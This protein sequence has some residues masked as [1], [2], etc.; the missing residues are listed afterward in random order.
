MTTAGTLVAM[1]AGASG[2][3]GSYQAT[4]LQA[5]STWSAGGNSGAFMWSYPMRVPPAPGGLAPKLSLDYSSQSVDGRHAAS[6]NQP[7]WIGEGFEMTAGGFIER[8]YKPCMKDMDGSANNDEETGDL[9]WETDNATLSLA[10]A[11]GELIYNAT[12]QRWHLRS[13]D[14]S[15][16]ERKTGASNGDNNGEYWVVT[17]T[18][19]VQYWFGANRLPGWASGD[20]VTNSTWTVPVFGNDPG[21]PCRATEF[22]DSDCVQAWRWNL[23]Y[24]VDL[25]GNSM[26][27]WYTK[28]TNR[29]GRDLDPD[30]APAYDRGGWLNRIDYGTRRDNGVDSVLDTPAPLRVDLG[31]AN[32]CLSNCATH[33]EVRWP[34][35]PWDTECAAAPCKDNFSPTFWR[36][37]RLSTVTTQFRAGGGYEDAERWTLSHTFPDPGDGTRAGLWLDRISHTGLV[38][39]STSLPDVEFTY[40]QLANRVDTIDFAAAMNWMRI[41]KIRNETGGTLNVTYSAP[42]CVAGQTP[43]A[44]TNTRR[45]YPVRWQP[46][47]H[48]DPVMD[49]F[50]KY[51]ITTLYETDHTGG[52]PPQGSPRVIHSFDYFGGAAWHYNDDDG[53]IDAEDKTWSDY[54]GYGRVG[55]TVGDPGEQ[56]YSE[57]RYF[58]GMHGDRAGPSGGT[59]TATVD[60]INDEDWYAGL[61]REKKTFNGPGGPVVSRETA[62][63]W[64]SPATATRTV[65]GDTV[66]ARFT[67]NGTVTT[68]TALDAGRGDRVTK[69]T[70]GYDSYGMPVSVDD[71]GEDGVAGDEVCTKTDYTPRNTTAWLLDRVHRVQK[72]AVKCAD[73]GGTLTEADVIGEART[74]Y[75]GQ[76]FESTPTRGLATRTEEMATWNSG[77]PTFTTVG[78][79]AYDAHGRET[80]SWDAMNFETKTAYTPTTG[81]PVTGTTVTNPMGHVTTTTLHPAWG[82][83]TVVVDPNGKRTDQAHDGLGRL[84]SVWLPGRDKAAQTANVTFSYQLRTDAATSVATARLNAAGNYVTNYALFD[85]M[86]RPRQTQAASPSGGRLLTETFYDSAGRKAREFALYHATGTPGDTLVTAT[87]PVHVPSQTRTVYDGASRVTAS[88]F[89][90]YADER[91]R[92]TTY[93]AG[94][95]TDVTPPAG[96][97]ATSTRTDARGRTVELRHYHGAIPTPG[98]AGTWDATSYNHNRKGQ[99]TGVTDPA[100]NDWTHTY[101]L[102]GRKVESTDPDL[103]TSVFTYDNAGRMTSVTDARGEKLAYLYDG[104][105]RKRAVYDDQLGGTMRAQWIYDTIAKGHLS[106]SI[107]FIGSAAYETK[108]VG[109]TDLYQPT[110][111]QIVIPAAETGL[112]GNYNFH[113][114]WNIDGSLASTSLPSTNGDLTAETLTYGYSDLGQLTNLSSD[115]NTN[116]SYVANTDYNALGQVDQYEFYTGTGGRVFQAFT[117]EL[118]TGRLTGVRT[119]RDQVAPYVLTDTSYSFDP[120]GNIDKIRDTAADPVDDTQCFGYD[121]LRRLTE[122]W[123]PA[124]GDCTAT[125]TVSGLG[126]PAPYS[127]SWTFNT[128][129]NRLSQVAHLPSGNATTNYQYPAT[130]AA[131]PHALTSTTGAEAGTYTYDQAGNT[132]TRPTPSA[133]TQTLTWDAEGQLDTSTDATGGTR[134]IYDAD[135]NRLIRRDPGGKTLYLPGQELRYTTGSSTT[136]CT[137]YYTFDGKTVA[138][139]TAAGLTWLS[140]DHQGTANVAVQAAT[141]QATSRRQSPYGTPRGLMASWPNSRGFVGGTVDN[142]GLVHLS[143]REY[144]PT[145][146][147]FIS[148]DPLQDLSDP[149]QWN[150][151]VY[152]NNTP[153]TMS[154]PS[155]LLGSAGCAPGMVGGPGGC[156]GNENG[157]VPPSG[158][159]T[160]SVTVYPGGTTLVQDNGRVWINDWEV[161]LE[162]LRT[163]PDAPT[164]EQMAAGLDRYHIEHPV[165]GEGGVDRYGEESTRTGILLATWAGGIKG[166]HEYKLWAAGIGGQITSELGGMQGVVGPRLPRMGPGPRI[167]AGCTNSFDGDTEV[168]L[169]DGDTKAIDEIEIGDVVLATDPETGRTVPRVVTDTI[170]GTGPKDLVDVTVDGVVIT[171]T[172]NHPFYDAG[173]RRWVD[174]KALRE[175]DLLRRPQGLTTVEQIR[176][177]RAE[178]RTVY[179]LTVDEIHT[180]YVIA[181]DTP[182]LVHNANSCGLPVRIKGGQQVAGGSYKLSKAEL[183]F[184]NDLLKRKP[185]FQVFRADGKASMG[186]FLVID[187]SNPRSPVGWAVEL[188][189]SSGGFPG[190]QFRNASSLTSRYGLSDFRMIAGTPSEMLDALSVGRSSWN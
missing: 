174:A 86:L 139:R 82:S 80:S 121:Y 99:P 74:W 170:V 138:S 50:H 169:A 32:R 39:G 81:G 88:V 154:D 84:T 188:K 180:Y 111:T 98:T 90:P 3:A 162:V 53:L 1:S 186:D 142:T 14:G 75:D 37:K 172:A 117:R 177:Y 166:S 94:D 83:P 19:G 144:D 143:A 92:T 54:R 175:G 70:T 63:P 124:S 66:T 72:Y 40:V 85:G 5:S 34:D 110:S 114:T 176:A 161:P 77:A 93:H 67:R 76:A 122:A 128:V 190:E 178:W 105:N 30:D 127:L 133:G 183:A 131:R 6:N 123:T 160:S 95:R 149:S 73:T 173:R 100:G 36:T 8:R 187:R 62:D 11:S 171:A 20:P 163:I 51:V 135:G 159:A 42:D 7:S 164:V 141:Q 157:H 45:C 146:G 104:L 17:T 120:A 35:T 130:G 118:E 69:V 129:G 2:P 43:T 132:L 26:S 148:V 107:R 61:T 167:G 155:G 10:G 96:G 56:T 145:I 13:D 115:Y 49:W 181:G 91:W 158:G 58:R 150:G 140:G 185:N 113:N 24:V 28:E 57:T 106:Q 65:N 101:D 168:L 21:E 31:E 116:A 109:Y 112:A 38:G 126:G 16:I 125:R 27:Y 15:R 151:Y 41:A 29:Y 119:D 189:T 103:G 68:Y 156:T 147:R 136:T 4:P 33:D 25:N 46:E 22:A 87:D 152:A 184:V 60:G 179:N 97:T 134:Y 23:D 44:H 59:R 9:C 182:V 165:R 79:K 48:Q 71:F 12:E 89:Q 18:G 52:V 47:G 108:I 64:A 153:I 102:R 137:R 78:R 55:V